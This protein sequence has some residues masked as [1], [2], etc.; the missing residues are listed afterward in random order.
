MIHVEERFA[1]QLDVQPQ[2]LR[3]VGQHALG[4]VFTRGLAFAAV[5]D[6]FR[7]AEGLG[8]A[9]PRKAVKQTLQCWP[10]KFRYVLGLSPVTLGN[11][12]WRISATRHEKSVQRFG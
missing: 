2:F 8:N 1:D 6:L 11:R 3:R 12:A 5:P 9:I 4:A 10:I 7:N